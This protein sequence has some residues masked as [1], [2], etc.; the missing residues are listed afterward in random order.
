VPLFVESMMNDEQV[1]SD[2]KVGTA[3]VVRIGDRVR[4]FAGPGAASVHALLRRIQPDSVVIPR[5]HRLSELSEELDYIEGYTPS[6]PWPAWMQTNDLLVDVAQSLAMIHRAT[7]PVVSS[8]NGPWWRWEGASQSGP[9]IRHG[10][11]WPAN[12]VF[13]QSETGAPTVVGW[14]DWDFAQPG[15]PVD[16]L[17]ALAKHWVPLMADDRAMAH[18][19]EL[20]VDRRHRLLL[21]LSAYGDPSVDA[22]HLVDAAIDFAS[23]TANSHR[24]WA[25]AG[26]PSFSAMVN[27]GITAAIEADGQWLS[28]NRDLVV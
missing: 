23:I 11:P 2:G 22:A 21:L 18:G 25:D 26:R 12:I 8:I 20:P 9:I 15:R 10:D 28:A 1:L 7:V 14:I 17:A 24:I 27:R 6:L 16:D 19:W 13:T 5:P 4:R 3:G